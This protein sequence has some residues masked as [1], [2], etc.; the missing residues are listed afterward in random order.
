[1]E[2][3]ELRG[4]LGEEQAAREAAVA[5][6]AAA[7]AAAEEAAGKLCAAQ[8]ELTRVRGA[9]AEANAK[10]A[11]AAAELRQ[12][13]ASQQAAKTAA[14]A[15]QSIVAAADT[16]SSEAAE[17]ALGRQGTP[18]G[19]QPHPV[20]AVDASG[21]ASLRTAVPGNGSNAPTSAAT[22]TAA[23]GVQEEQTEGAAGAVV[24]GSV[25][26]LGGAG[27]VLAGLSAV[28][29]SEQ[30]EHAS[31]QARVLLLERHLR[32]LRVEQEGQ[33]GAGQGVDQGATQGVTQGKERGS[34][35]G[36]WGGQEQEQQGQQQ[37]KEQRSWLG[38]K[39]RGVLGD[40]TNWQQV[41][42][43]D[44]Q[45]Q[46]QKQPSAEV[47]A[48][49]VQVHHSAL[50][51]LQK[52]RD[53]QSSGDE[54]E[55]QSVTLTPEPQQQARSVGSES[56]AQASAGPPVLPVLTSAEQGGMGT[57]L[58][59]RRATDM[60]AAFMP[61][62][63]HGLSLSRV[64]VERSRLQ[65][66]SAAQ[67]VAAAAADAVD[68]AAATAPP[69]SLRWSSDAPSDEPA[70]AHSEWAAEARYMVATTGV[71]RRALQV[72]SRHMLGQASL[73]T[74]GGYHDPGS[75]RALLHQ[76]GPVSEGEVVGASTWR[77]AEAQGDGTW[78][79]SRSA[80]LARLQ[81]R[82]FG[83]PPMAGVGRRAQLP[84][85]P[86]HGSGPH[87]QYQ[88]QY[89][90]QPTGQGQYRS[91]VPV[92]RLAAAA[93]PQV[94]EDLR[95]R[96][97]TE[98]EQHQQQYRHQQQAE[99]PQRP[100]AARRATADISL[101]DLA[102]LHRGGGGHGDS[103]SHAPSHVEPSQRH[104]SV[105]HPPQPL[106]HPLLGGGAAAGR[107]SQDRSS[108]SCGS[109]PS[110]APALATARSRAAPRDRTPSAADTPPPPR[111]RVAN[112]RYVPN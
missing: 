108:S 15:A 23:A 42:S 45:K 13:R 104:G 4:Q 106:P 19:G 44:K 22:P 70:A 109:C 93:A 3:E 95:G 72:D 78:P 73:L 60:A 94:G 110:A 87:G 64:H 52:Q 38:Q 65:E 71:S 74:A 82:S 2:A 66:W 55:V 102:L 6:A 12:A 86:Y 30:A 28:S 50:D 53:V 47:Q 63:L 67:A 51:Q 76:R 25:G 24:S 105:P 99:R 31:L 77:G 33:P 39:E 62:V 10:A 83:H 98:G 69:A 36:G 5:A 101:A 91:G 35:A 56:A 11:E 18:P 27:G 92:D 75:S 49:A 89:T 20:Q 96:R 88:Q 85:H 26:P 111:A 46:E 37:G 81:H 7:V 32:Q 103:S 100:G 80:D 8:A 9:L 68:A 58:G 90:Q 54:R 21:S 107:V 1:M 14:T 61:E 34:R 112:Q 29:A 48:A 17:A 79:L 41:D 97:V 16:C 40:L 84:P 59:R 57:G 43:Q